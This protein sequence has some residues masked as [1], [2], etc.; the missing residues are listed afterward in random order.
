MLIILRALVRRAGWLLL[1]FVVIVAVLA[2]VNEL[3]AKLR[4]WQARADNAEQVAAKLNAT[5]PQ[6]EEAARDAVR[7]ADSDIAAL[8][9]AS[10]TRLAAAERNIADRR[11]AAEARVSPGI[12]LDAGKIAA[13]Y[14]ARY[15]EL[16]LLDRTA[17]LIALRR[18]NLREIATRQMQI[19]SLK[20]ELAQHG[21]RVK[22]F[23]TRVRQLNQ[24]HQ[25]SRSQ[26]RS[27]LCERAAQ[28]PGCSLVR[29]IRRRDAELQRVR[30]PLR[31]NAAVLSAKQAAMKALVLRREEVADGAAII[32]NATSGYKAKAR[33]L[34]KEASGYAWNQAENRLWRYG[35][36]A[37]LVLLGS[38]LLPILYKLCAFLIVA[39]LAAR[40][41]PVRL[42][43]AVPPLAASASG[44]SVEVAL[45]RDSELLLRSGLQSSAADIHGSDKYVLDC[46]IP[47]S[48]IAA[49]LVNLQQLRSD[50][51]D[52]VVVTGTDGSHRVTAIAVPT[53]G[54]VVLQP[55]ALIGVV[56]PRGTR[57]VITR[58]WRI[59]WLISWITA[60]FRYIVFH[61]PCTLIV[62]GRD[63]VIVEDTAR[64]RMI[65]K[66]L[67]LGFDAGIAYGAARSSS[68]LPYLRGQAS[69]FNDRFHGAGSY[70]YEQR[71]AGAGKGGL[72]GRGLKGIGDAALGALGI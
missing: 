34:S 8:K 49:G 63:G 65:N 42:L 24:R 44:I 5:V 69:L 23:R 26:W 43:H 56:K 14:R 50:R 35:R 7:D 47:F 31:N 61:G 16:P 45:D 51:P 54:A 3:P 29:E 66:R 55:R 68:F 60:Q 38:V 2:I 36:I 71:A 15:V 37:F 13:G 48:C 21:K 4:E 10:D 6:F 9:Q 32:A 53:G 33:E 41:R 58:P 27:P 72:W 52:H 18:A 67:T 64:G 57:L 25:R 28:L 62:Q 22:N 40:T 70:F 12:T 19:R 20:Q 1:S 46:R 39:P 59:F 30:G 17:A 11:T